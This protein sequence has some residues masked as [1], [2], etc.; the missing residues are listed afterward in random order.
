MTA[1]ARIGISALAVALLV[2][3]MHGVSQ[4][5]QLAI[6]QVQFSKFYLSKTSI[7]YAAESYYAT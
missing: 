5:L 1:R 2:W 3:H 6:D 7:T 4:K